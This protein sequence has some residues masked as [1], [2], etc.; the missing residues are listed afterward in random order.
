[1]GKWHQKEG[2]KRVK[3][4]G[5]PIHIKYRQVFLFRFPPNDPPFD[6]A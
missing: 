6:S 5:L 1:M 2:Q 4:V 3:K